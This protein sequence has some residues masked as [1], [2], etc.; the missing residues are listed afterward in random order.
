MVPSLQ[1][2]LVT[3]LCAALTSAEVTCGEGVSCPEIAAEAVQ[4]SAMLQVHAAPSGES[5]APARGTKRCETAILDDT[6]LFAAR[7]CLPEGL[8]EAH[9]LALRRN[10]AFLA[11][12]EVEE[13]DSEQDPVT[14]KTASLDAAGFK[15]A[16]S[17]CCPG[18]MEQFFNR[19]LTSKGLEVCSKPHV[20]GMVHWF[21]CVPDMDFQY[22]LDIINNGN[23][24]K[25]WALSGTACPELSPECDPKWCR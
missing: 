21:S 2:A 18:D 19:L 1:F 7:V 20:Q 6:H 3:L 8:L 23:P 9:L 4:G 14:G 16:T 5:K 10:A 24:C 13:E 11:T 25:Y 12:T 17:L 15:A 22:V